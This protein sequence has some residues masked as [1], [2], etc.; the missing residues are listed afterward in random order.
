MAPPVPSG[1]N[2]TQTTG[3]GSVKA[4]FSSLLSPHAKTGVDQMAANPALGGR[5]TFQPPASRASVHW[6]GSALMVEIKELSIGDKVTVIYHERSYSSVVQDMPTPDTL[7]IAQPTNMGVYL[8][9]I[10][11]DE[12]EILFHKENGI[13][14]FQV[15]QEERFTLDSMRVLR[16][17]AVTE[18]IRSQRRSFFRLEKSLPIQVSVKPEAETSG[19]AYTFKARTINI[20]GG[21]CRIAI[22]QPVDHDTKLECKISLG[23]SLDL[24][25]DGQVVWVERQTGGDK[26]NIIG[27]QFVD[28]DPSAQKQLIGYVLGEQRRQLQKNR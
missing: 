14:T 15:V 12:G 16:L 28:E 10:P 18:V 1:R 5:G 9:I 7:I 23:P 21:G 27:V 8:D 3:Q 26:T 11:P 4:Y 25:L 6:R 19:E 22:K 13:M 17:R 2:T 20:S 24:V